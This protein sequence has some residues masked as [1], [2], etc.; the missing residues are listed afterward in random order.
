MFPADEAGEGTVIVG[1]L[2]MARRCSEFLQLPVSL[3]MSRSLPSGGVS[4]HEVHSC[5]LEAGVG[6]MG[7]SGLA[8]L[9]HFSAAR[10]DW[11]L[12]RHR[13]LSAVLTSEIAGQA[14]LDDVRRHLRAVRGQ[15]WPPEWFGAG[16]S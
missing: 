2:T 8:W 6:R 3:R 12:R 4:A 15:A 9:L 7:R 11:L 5:W 10:H 1:A 13:R 14:V 16:E